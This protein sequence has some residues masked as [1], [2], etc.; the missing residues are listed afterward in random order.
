[1]LSL[2]LHGAGTRKGVYAGISMTKKVKSSVTLKANQSVRNVAIA[3]GTVGRLANGRTA[4]YG[5][6]AKLRIVLTALIPVNITPRL[7]LNG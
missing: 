5:I 6:I 4:A 2:Q 7:A 1:M 3:P